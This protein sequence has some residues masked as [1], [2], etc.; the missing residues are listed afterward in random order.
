LTFLQGFKI[1]YPTGLDPAIWS[2]TP[3]VVFYALLPLLVL[4]L[5]GFYGRLVVLGALFA[6]SLVTRLLM[7]RGAFDLLPVVGEHLAGNRLYFFPTTLLYLFIVGML[8]RMAVERVD[9]AR[10][11]WRR[12]LLAAM[13]VVPA[14]LLVAFPY[15]IMRGGLIRS[16]LAMV[17]EALVI[18]VFASVLFGSPV[19]RPALNWRPL[20]F[21]GQISYSLFLLHTTV[22]FLSMRYL[23]F[24]NRLWFAGQSEPVVWAAFGAYTAFVLSVS[25]LLAYLSYRFV[26]SPFL[27]RKPK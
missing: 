22:I 11:P 27:R 15:L 1:P 7:S 14:A 2:L 26:E 4:K 10:V 17:A 3:E 5:R 25:I 12:W 9:A 18:L 24:P 13:T 21:V 23:L 6:V 20:V 19:T 16:P 8:L